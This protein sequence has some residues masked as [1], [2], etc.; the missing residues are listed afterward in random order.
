M[1]DSWVYKVSIAAPPERVWPLVG[2]L[3]RHGEWSP[4]PYRVEWLSGEPNAAGSAFRSIGWLPQ[5]K[6]H[7]MEGTVE[8]SEPLKVFEV[9]THDDKEEWR[10]RYELTPSGS[11]TVVTKTATGP[12]MT[13]AK[14]ALRSAIFA[15]FVSRGMQKGLDNLR[16]RAET[17]TPA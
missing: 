15:A 3:G 14:A 13:G 6:E 10:N 12:H 7:E 9:L 17:A 4:K 11:G 5:D 8:V 1:G 2:D 16:E